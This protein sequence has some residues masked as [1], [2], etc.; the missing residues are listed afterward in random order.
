MMYTL[1]QTVLIWYYGCGNYANNLVQSSLREFLVLYP[2]LVQI[3]S[4]WVVAMYLILVL[5]QV[6]MK[7]IFQSCSLIPCRNYK[8]YSVC[9]D[10][11]TYCV[12]LIY[13]IFRSKFL[14]SIQE[15]YIHCAPMIHCNGI[16]MALIYLVYI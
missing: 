14:H 8:T 13:C 15:I 12:E 7:Y 4:S 1:F 6:M 3:S 9:R 16:I 10:Y 11:E 5:Y 2:F